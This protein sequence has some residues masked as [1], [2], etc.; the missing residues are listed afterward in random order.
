MGLDV[1]M[2]PSPQ[3]VELYMTAWAAPS[4]SVIQQGRQVFGEIHG[5]LRQKNAWIC[6]E[7]VFAA[8]ADVPAL[9]RIRQQEYGPFND[10]V[11]PT[12]LAPKD[13]TS[14]ALA[15]Q[16]HAVAAHKPSIISTDSAQARILRLDGCCW[17]MASGLRAGEA[18]DG[19]AQTR[20]VFQ[21]ARRL[22]VE[23]GG[24]LRDLAR[25]WIF[26]D[27]ILS[28]YGQ[29]NQSRSGFFK[30][31]GLLA[32]GA[33]AQFPASTG[34]GISPADGSKCAMDLLAVIGPEGSV[35]RH[36]AA[37]RQRSAN[38]YGSAF[39]RAAVAQTP[40]G[41]TIF[42]SGTA[43]IDAAGITCFPNNIAGQIQMTLENVTAVLRQLKAEP[44]DVVQA[45]A[46]CAN[47]EERQEFRDRW[48]AKMPWPWLIVMGDV[49]RHDLLFEVEATACAGMRAI[50]PVAQ[51]L[52]TQEPH[53]R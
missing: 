30:E 18:G 52:A 39:A 24:D 40:A 12:F 27:D 13:G 2:I 33:A 9:R 5:L 22:L 44:A 15:V 17:V 26:M 46:Y 41:K 11:E 50:S 8:G 3:A 35:A 31:H 43:A 38:E 48:A 16:V 14:D 32:P 25:T 6:Q 29:F 1:R 34:I 23:A 47:S 42:I 21:K 7:R 28:W 4:G 10:G 36:E 51:S 20:A 37:G 19:P 53:M 45:V 49:C